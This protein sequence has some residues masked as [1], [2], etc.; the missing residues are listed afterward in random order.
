MGLGTVWTE[1]RVDA[2]AW[3][4]HDG[5]M[6]AG[7][8]VEAGQADLFLISYLGIDFLT[9]GERVYRLLGC[10]LTFH[11][12]PARPGDRLSYEI[13]VDGH[14]AQGGVRLFF[15]HY[16]A[17]TNGRLSMTVRNGQ[18]G[19]FTDEEL[20]Q[21]RGGLW[22][23]AEMRPQP[24]ERVD[25][26]RVEPVRASL[27]PEE[28]LAFARGD[29]AAGFGP[30]FRLAAS[31][32]RT[33][34]L[35]LPP[36]LLIDRVTT[37]AV[38]GG[39]LGRGY[40]RAESDIRGDE[41]F[42]QGHFHDDPAM[43]GTLM[44]ES[45]LQAMSIY[46]AALGF[47]LDKDGWRF[48]PATGRPYR[49]AC[50]G[51]VTPAPH[52]L[53]YEVFVRSVV[54]G[55]RPSVTAD[56]VAEVDGLQAFHCRDLC[57]EL[58]PDWPITS[59]LGLSPVDLTAVDP[60]VL[61][62]AWGQPSAVFGEAY[63]PFDDERRTPRLPGPP[64]L[65]IS[66]F[67][68]FSGPRGGMAVGSALEAEFDVSPDAWYFPEGE[69]AT[70]PL[71]AL[72]E[73]A[74][75]PCGALSAYVGVP[76]RT[77]EDVHVRNLDGD[78]R[79]LASVPRAR[80]RLVTRATLQSLSTMGSTTIEAFHVT[81]ALDGVPVAEVDSVFGHFTDEALGQQAGFGREG[82]PASADGSG[83]GPVGEA[84]QAGSTPLSMLERLVEW[85][86][87]GGAHG[88]GRL[89]GE[90][91]VDP[92]AWFF[93]AHFYQDPVQPGSLGLEAMAELVRESIV[94]RHGPGRGPGVAWQSLA[95]EGLSWQYRGQVVGTNRRV[96]VAVEISASGV[97]ER[98]PYAYGD[99]T[100]WVDGL[101][102]YRARRVGVRRVDRGAAA[103]AVTL[104][105]GWLGAADATGGWRLDPD[106]QP[107]LSDHRPTFARPVLPLAA[108][109]DILAQAA[110]AEA[111]AGEVVALRNV[112]A[113]RWLV[114]DRPLRLTAAV[115][116]DGAAASG[117]YRVEARAAEDGPVS[118]QAAPMCFAAGEVRV[119][120]RWSE[121]LVAAPPPL[122]AARPAPDPYATGVLFHGPSL[123]VIERLAVGENG[124]TAHLSAAAADAVP[125]LLPLVVLDGIAQ[126]VG[127]DLPS[128]GM[129]DWAPGLMAFPVGLPEV[130]LYARVPTRGSLRCEVRRLTG[131][132]PA[133]GALVRF[134]AH[135]Y[136]ADVLLA[137]MRMDTRLL[138]AG[139]PGA[140]APADR[141]AFLTGARFVPGGRIATVGDGEADAAHLEIARLNWL[142]GTLEALYGT[143]RVGPAL[144]RE[145]VGKDLVGQLAE[146]PPAA[147]SLPATGT[148]E[149]RTRHQPLNVYP[150]AVTDRPGGARAR[151]IGPGYLDLAPLADRA[152]RRTGVEGFLMTD[153]WCALVAHT[154]RRLVLAQPEAFT[155][156][157]G[158]PLL[159]LANHQ[160]GLESVA[161]SLLA[162]A[163]TDRDVA[164]VAKAEH[165]HSWIGRLQAH[166]AAYPGVCL[167][168]AMLF[169]DRSRPDDILAVHKDAAAL[170][171]R[172]GSLLVHVE[173]TRALSARHRMGAVSGTWLDL[174]IA[175]GVAVVP[176]RFVGGLPVEPA[177]ERQEFGWRFAR[178]D[179]FLGPP[180]TP[181]AMRALDYRERTRTLVE[182][183]EALGP[184]PETEAPGAPEPA[185]ERAVEAAVRTTGL[186]R[187]L[188]AL[189]VF[190]RR[191]PT[192]GREAAYL[193]GLDPSAPVG[194]YGDARD[195][196][197]E[198]SRPFVLRG[199]R[200][201]REE[202]R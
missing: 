155:R 121:A 67:T 95:P 122:E 159:F 154:V 5:A 125:A 49:M 131:E 162:S 136:D 157:A 101:C 84:L 124:V 4:M 62:A 87:A 10:D 14:S 143:D 138:P 26:P 187:P 88:L 174:A 41:W 9:Q 99:G 83:P 22:S 94:R 100:L 149:A 40:L 108:M 66:R 2:D 63:R 152:A 18:A 56:V 29:L 54:A 12:G 147:V 76:L 141:R 185:L 199:A 8:M 23:P 113:E 111:G 89:V 107:W 90:M 97:D 68:A 98:G 127:G 188:A 163:L 167:P 13:H 110:R 96:V 116:G 172:G 69:A 47:S 11:E 106:R 79:L 178:Q 201:R 176:V 30:A 19:F 105:P 184:P 72:V 75:Q 191:W 20:R 197:L 169:V 160:T 134:T 186:D 1:S 165:R 60:M 43:P 177:P 31:H 144:T 80:G 130:R 145:I 182:A 195:G 65:F 86:P 175:E 118:G 81:V 38:A 193:I 91:D 166:A 7:A 48:A 104:C 74:L 57:L 53:V 42:F 153:V 179:I 28:V 17:H 189:A 33:P 55:P 39:P 156:A 194:L 150:L 59:A 50:R 161:F 133:V 173:G 103:D 93:R 139:P 64:Y 129:S 73:V 183:I 16:D 109:A 115:T 112:R 46:L 148:G 135:L 34:R 85:A 70:M 198:A 45:C 137:W 170:F 171:A 123:Q 158:A 51:Q 77:A 140:L 146:V 126:C 44:F 114:V 71:A 119:A 180:L 132:R 117:W 190:L 37:I 151:L 192:P 78:L 15:F 92:G 164:A 120:E 24:G 142:P 35:P 6:L 25:P 202:G 27:G 3:Y 82:A 200:R 168:E 21:S 181:E 196:W 32:V 102:I 61:H 52:K 128:V 58:R 36:L